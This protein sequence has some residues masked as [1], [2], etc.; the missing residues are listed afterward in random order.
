MSSSTTIVSCVSQIVDRYQ[1]VILDQWGVLHDGK[2]LL[3]GASNFLSR[4]HDAGIPVCLIT[5]SSK[6][7]SFN[8][9]RL[10]ELFG[11]T[12]DHYYRVFSSFD[13]LCD[14]LLT[15]RRFPVL[16]IAVEGE[17]QFLTDAGIPITESAVSA[18]AVAIMSVDPATP[19]EAFTDLV[20]LAALRNLP[21]SCIC[22]DEMRIVSG[23]NHCGVSRIVTAFSSACSHIYAAGKPESALYERCLEALPGIASQAILAVGDQFSSDVRGANLAG[24]ASALVLTGVERQL[25]IVDIEKLPK[26]DVPVWIAGML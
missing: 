18:A 10:E 21:V 26:S 3:P 23:V 7:A 4:L 1:A 19:T 24:I 13:V 16:P 5:N 6:P 8:C 2:V 25:Q 20:R 17:E 14:H 11:V 9:R 12:S 15:Q 22:R